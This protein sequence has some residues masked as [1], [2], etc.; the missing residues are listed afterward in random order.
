MFDYLLNITKY[1]QHPIVNM[2]VKTE[3]PLALPIADS[4]K[5]LD[6]EGKQA[7]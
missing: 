4:A 7:L 6:A 2:F 5:E 1:A 3:T